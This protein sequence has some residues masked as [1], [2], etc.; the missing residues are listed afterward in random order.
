[1]MKS[2]AKLYDES[3]RNRMQT[4]LALIE[5][6]A[7]LTIGSVIGVIILGVILAITSV[8]DVAF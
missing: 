4:V 7:I 3:S 8:N 2:L 6:I 5:P 1:M